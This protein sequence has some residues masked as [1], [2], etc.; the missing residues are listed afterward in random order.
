MNA[1]LSGKHQFE[2]GTSV[3]RQQFGALCYRIDNGKLQILLVT[4]R[5]TGR[6]II[7]KGWPEGDLDPASSA[8][9]EAWEEAGVVGVC[10]P[11]NLG[12]F[13]YLKRRPSKGNIVC[14]VEVFPLRVRKLAS[15]YPEAGQRRRK[16][17]SRKKAAQRVS[18]PGL[19]GILR[20]FR[21]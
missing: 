14:L 18:D 3:V 16:W 13:S 2:T 15:D 20:E 12:R 19:A 21:P 10:K 8:S 17:F 6:W 5:D 7:P 11:K 4:S 1:K 9:R